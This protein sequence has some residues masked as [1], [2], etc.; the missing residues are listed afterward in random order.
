M[1]GATSSFVASPSFHLHDHPSVDNVFAASCTALLLCPSK[2]TEGD[3]N[4]KHTEN[5]QRWG[6]IK[7]VDKSTSQPTFIESNLHLV[8]QC[9]SPSLN[10]P[11]G[12]VLFSISV[13]LSLSVAAWAMVK[14]GLLLHA[15]TWRSHTPN[16]CLLIHAPFSPALSIYL[17]PAAV[18]GK[19]TFRL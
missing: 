1:I 11:G 17:T 5:A 10:Q 14:T 15:M 13:C 4:C 2:S 19:H 18:K 3:R 16:Q 9:N 12:Q 6:E 7:Q 8:E